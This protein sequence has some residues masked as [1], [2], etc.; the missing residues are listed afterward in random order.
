MRQTHQAGKLDCTSANGL[1][2]SMVQSCQ[3][4]VTHS[5]S[6]ICFT[7]HPHWHCRQCLWASRAHCSCHWFDSIP[8]VD[9]VLCVWVCSFHTPLYT[10]YSHL[11]MMG[12]LW[13]YWAKDLMYEFR[14]DRTGT[15]MVRSW[16]PKYGVNKNF[17]RS[18]CPNEHQ[19]CTSICDFEWSKFD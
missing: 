6:T 7:S 9:R 18:I 11:R 17:C 16:F 1:S 15:S 12:K 14:T 10:S 5:R 4:G 2:K 13:Y 3:L 8:P 19:C